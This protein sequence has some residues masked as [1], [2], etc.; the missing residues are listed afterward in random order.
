MKLNPMTMRHSFLLAT[1]FLGR[2]VQ[3][4]RFAASLAV[5]VPSESGVSAG[6]AVFQ[7]E[8]FYYYANVQRGTNGATLS[9]ECF[10]GRGGSG[11][12]VVKSVTLA[13]VK[14]VTLR[15]A[16]SDAK[17]AFEYAADSGAW[18]SLVADQDA[19]L[20]TTDVAGGFVGATVGPHT[21]LEA[22]GQGAL[23]R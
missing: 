6:L 22:G 21:R 20:L 3:H 18:E 10:R 12:E 7:G 2:R 17:C 11:P 19:R 15:V 9:L 4:S 1:S 14:W 8:R 13:D 16:A 23:P 5:E